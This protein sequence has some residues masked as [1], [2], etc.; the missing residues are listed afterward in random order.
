MSRHPKEL[1]NRA[2][3]RKGEALFPTSQMGRTMSQEVKGVTPRLS[4]TSACFSTPVRSTLELHQPCRWDKHPS[5][6]AHSASPLLNPKADTQVSPC[7]AR[8]YNVLQVSTASAQILKAGS[9]HVHRWTGF[10]LDA[11]PF[12]NRASRGNNPASPLPLPPIA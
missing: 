9:L 3:F 11:K 4:C 10:K 2:I 6:S 7:W 1:N 5:C 8:E 12:V